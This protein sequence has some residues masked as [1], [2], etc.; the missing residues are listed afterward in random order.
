MMNHRVT[1]SPEPRE[2]DLEG[3]P[4]PGSTLI[5]HEGK[6][7]YIPNGVI[8][9]GGSTS[10]SSVTF[11]N[12][13]GVVQ[14]YHDL[15]MVGGLIPG[16][17]VYVK[18][19]QTIYTYSTDGLWLNVGFKGTFSTTGDIPVPGPQGPQ[20]AQGPPGKGVTISG[21]TGN[22]SS[23]TPSSAGE[24]YITS[25]DNHIHI[26]DGMKWF[27]HG[28]FIGATG[29]QGIEGPTGPMGPHGPQG[30]TGPR[31]MDNIDQSPRG[32][33]GPEGHRGPHGPTGP[34][35]PVGPRGQTGIRG[36][37]GPQ[38]GW[39]EG[40]PVRTMASKPTHA[41]STNGEIIIEN[42]RAWVWYNLSWY[43]FGLVRGPGGP[44]GPGG[45]IGP[46]GPAGP[47]GPTGPTG[48]H[49]PAGP[50]GPPGISLR[51]TGVVSDAG[52]LPVPG[53]LGEIRI[54][55]DDKRVHFR[56]P[57]GW[58]S[59][60]H[61]IQGATGPHGPPTVIGPRGMT[62]IAGSRMSASGAPR[63]PPGP[64]GPAGPRGHAGKRGPSG[65][66]GER[67]PTGPPGP[68]GLPGP[69]GPPGQGL[70]GGTRM[71]EYVYWDHSAFKI[72]S[73]RVHL[74]TTRYD[75]A[76]QSDG[77][78]AIGKDTVPGGYQNRDAIAVGVGAGY[79]VQGTGSVAVGAGA[80]QHQQAYSVAVGSG[81]G[82]GGQRSYSTAVGH[83]AGAI[84]QNTFAVAV[85]AGAGNRQQGSFAVALGVDAGHTLQGTGSIAVGTAAGKHAQGDYAVAL[86]TEAGRD[87][88][89]A[90]TI[91][92]GGPITTTGTDRTFIEHVRPTTK[93]AQSVKGLYYSSRDGEIQAG[94][95]TSSLSRL[96]GYTHDDV[97]DVDYSSP[98]S[99]Q[100]SGKWGQTRDDVTRP[101]TLYQGSVAW[102]P[103]RTTHLGIPPTAN[104]KPSIRHPRV[105]DEYLAPDGLVTKLYPHGS[106]TFEYVPPAGLG[107]VM[108]LD[109]R[110]VWSMQPRRKQTITAWSPDR[111]DYIVGDFAVYRHHLYRFTNAN[112]VS[113]TGLPPS[114]APAST[115]TKTL[116]AVVQDA[117]ATVIEN[118]I[119][120]RTD[121]E[122]ALAPDQWR[123]G[124]CWLK[125]GNCL[126]WEPRGAGDTLPTNHYTWKYSN[127]GELFI[128]TGQFDAEGAYTD[129]AGKVRH[130]ECGWMRVD[131]WTGR[132][133]HNYTPSGTLTPTLFM[134]HD[135]LVGI[136]PGWV[137]H[138]PVSHDWQAIAWMPTIVGN[139]IPKHNQTL[140]YYAADDG[141]RYDDAE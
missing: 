66:K 110:R 140:K 123:A 82:R 43:D 111:L 130:L 33:R 117:P 8:T 95:N 116:P 51:V 105:G 137:P 48:P 21:V 99:I 24:T 124:D 18:D 25:H 49:G 79:I 129:Q 46:Q 74:G 65:P 27:D 73:Q 15:D 76:H 6:W 5:L 86:G 23:I 54:S 16:R 96:I 68:Q 97:E 37:W 112:G 108:T 115:T 34:T 77:A 122:Y 53:V 35:G 70:P 69:P 127:H 90:R 67:G 128:Y 36:V 93:T 83:D 84:N 91:A 132:F 101:R 81:A 47:V 52:N 3:D 63:G 80:G 64:Q 118:G 9:A 89:H 2:I 45:Y 133:Q 100:S 120:T 114:P 141:W 11:S 17:T 31:G 102:N 72:G 30:V 139:Q 32:P 106:Q 20:G 50:Q 41:G 85:G 38:G 78:I 56:T 44:V 7:V 60:T 103:S 39:G 14:S 29:P 126:R 58:V 57:S 12:Q 19:H 10:G 119:L 88:Q 4:I 107:G 13:I 75:D 104:P 92:L 113:V 135:T 26:W 55:M 40:I 28:E 125:F 87:S 138:A 109:S 1:Q 134:I 61:P 131:E 42:G 62:G 121:S 94:S 22:L 71:G 136:H 59:T 98:L